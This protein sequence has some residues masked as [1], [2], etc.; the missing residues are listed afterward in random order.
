MHERPRT[1][2]PIRARGRPGSDAHARLV[3]LERDIRPDS[4]LYVAAG[5]A[6]DEIRRSE[7]YH[8]AGFSSFEAY[9]RERLDISRAY[10]YRK[11]A[12]AEVI[13]LLREAGSSRLPTNEAQARELVALAGDAAVLH[14][15]WLAVLSESDTA[16]TAATVRA[17]VA[18]FASNR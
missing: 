2:D 3:R 15:A 5:E 12:A 17:V 1:S 14:E 10:A 9:V 16:P 6:L 13:G 8:L 18:R 11:M 7:L 4:G